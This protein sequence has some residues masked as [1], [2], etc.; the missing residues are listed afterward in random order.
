MRLWL[1]KRLDEVGRDEYAGFVVRA[2]DS[3]AARKIACEVAARGATP[4][5]WADPRRSSC[6]RLLV[7]GEAGVVLADFKAG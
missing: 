7:E 2:P 6:E 5:A 1:L 3:Y 4:E